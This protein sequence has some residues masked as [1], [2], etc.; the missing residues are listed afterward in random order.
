[1][2][3]HDK[4]AVVTGGAGGIGAAVVEQLV[5]AGATAYVWDL[6]TGVDIT[7]RA[8]VEAA[9]RAAGDVDI[10]VNGAGIDVIGPF[11]ESD[12]AD[13]RRTVEVNLLGTIRCCQV[14]AT[15]M[16]DRGSGAIINIASDAGRV[17][18]SGEAVYSG[19][20]GGIIAFTKAL[21]REVAAAGVRVNCVC[22][23]PTETALLRQVAEYSQKLYDGLARAIPMRRI[24]QPDDIAA[25][26]AFLA[27]DAA[28]YITGQ[29]LS[30]S[31]GLTM[32]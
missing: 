22:P 14:L 21:A 10:L 32:A 8:S 25:A 3:D 20:K 16:V 27:S 19:T 7:D 2:G 12:E 26:V 5:A 29:T 31:G 4:T 24:G 18:S 23:G 17:G 6:E 1:M 13:W 11:L 9:A 30:V 28:G 15:G